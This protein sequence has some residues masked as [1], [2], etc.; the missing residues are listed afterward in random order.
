MDARLRWAGVHKKWNDS[1]YMH[2]CVYIYE[3]Q[4]RWRYVENTWRGALATRR[5]DATPDCRARDRGA[6]VN[7]L[8]TN[9]LLRYNY[10]RFRETN[11]RYIGILLLVSV[12]TILPQSACMLNTPQPTRSHLSYAMGLSS[13]NIGQAWNLL[14]WWTSGILYFNFH[15]THLL[16]I[17]R[18]IVLY[19]IT[20]LHPSHP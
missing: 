16:C 13:T 5:A 9:P 17:H 19:H 8:Y 7:R 10:F 3:V 18:P 14:W 12:S 1:L 20:V 11:V 6:S 15:C 4:G 2:V